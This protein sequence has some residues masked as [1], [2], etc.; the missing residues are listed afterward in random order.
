MLRVNAQSKA[1]AR[2]SAQGR[3]TNKQHGVGLAT[4]RCVHGSVKPCQCEALLHVNA[5]SKANARASVQRCATSKQHGVGL[6]TQRRVHVLMLV[7]PR[8]R[9][10]EK[11][12]GN[13]F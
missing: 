2:S 3:A 10:A 7:N 9:K 1:N 13:K 12:I 6:A 4:Q 11:L 5:Q 8:L